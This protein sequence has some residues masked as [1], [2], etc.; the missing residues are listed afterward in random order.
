[1]SSHHTKNSVSIGRLFF[2]LYSFFSSV[3]FD[4]TT[5]SDKLNT[6]LQEINYD[7]IVEIKDAKQMV[8]MV[9]GKQINKMKE[10]VLLVILSL[11]I[12]LGQMYEFV[13]LYK[14]NDKERTYC[15]EILGYGYWAINAS[16]FLEDFSY[17][18][19]VGLL[20][21]SMK[22]SR[23][24]LLILFIYELLIIYLNTKKRRIIYERN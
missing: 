23:I 16:L 11:T 3:Y 7:Q 15:K 20:C 10:P 6:L 13:I 4:K 8:D 17:Y 24:I 18:L 19:F 1:M 21:R 5:S 9:R 12:L 14:E 22:Y 2:F